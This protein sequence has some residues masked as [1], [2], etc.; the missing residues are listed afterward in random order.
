MTRKKCLAALLTISLLYVLFPY[1]M[2]SASASSVERTIIM[3]PYFQIYEDHF[4][5]LSP[6]DNYTISF[7]V[8]YSQCLYSVKAYGQDNSSLEVEWVYQNET[9]NLTLLVHTNGQTSFTL[10]TILHYTTRIVNESYYT[11]VNLYPCAEGEL[12]AALTLFL[13]SG[14]TLVDYPESLSLTHVDG[15]P[16]LIGGRVLTPFEASNDTIA[17]NGTYQ[18]VEITNLERRI[19]ASASGVLVTENVQFVNLNFSI[20]KNFKLTLPEGASL[21]RVYDS[22]GYMNYTLENTSLYVALRSIILPSE[23]SSFTIVYQIPA[24][25][26]YQHEND[27]LVFS[28][29]VLPEWC[30]YLVNKLNTVI[31][32]PG[33][34]S[35]VEGIGVTLVDKNSTVEGRIAATDITPYSDFSFSI[36]FIPPPYTIPSGAIVLVS[37]VVMIAVIM[38]IYIRVLRKREPVSPPSEKKIPS[39]QKRHTKR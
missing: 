21:L 14:S 4:N 3:E 24:S 33:G 30:P 6:T 17:Y 22:I 7:V 19:E 37:L 20:M 13:P 18:L 1:T 8:P 26:A 29:S 15:R 9:S 31:S 23:K 25:N 12:S 32:L 10:R 5:L 36:S 16:A 34:A 39:Q 35:Q 27:K 28:G 38:L 11:T 2:V